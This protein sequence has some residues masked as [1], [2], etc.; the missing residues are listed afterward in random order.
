MSGKGLD[1]KLTEKAATALLKHVAKTKSSAT[2]VRTVFAAMRSNAQ[3]HQ[4]RSTSTIE[5]TDLL[6]ICPHR[7]NSW[8][9]PTQFR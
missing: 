2:K 6:G 1:K 9:H 5:K 4:R 3:T 7:N 8:I